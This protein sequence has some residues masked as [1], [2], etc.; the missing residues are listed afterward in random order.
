MCGFLK[1][2][3][4]TSFYV[5]IFSIYFYFYIYFY[6]MIKFELR[7]NFLNFSYLVCEEK[8]ETQII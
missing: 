7:F 8:K 4:V 6:Y 5:T 1:S 3:T 2:F